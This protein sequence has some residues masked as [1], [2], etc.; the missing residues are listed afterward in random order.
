MT[1]KTK[2]IR[3][4]GKVVHCGLYFYLGD[5]T[6]TTWWH[7]Y[8]TKWDDYHFGYLKTTYVICYYNWELHGTEEMERPN[9]YMY[10]IMWFSKQKSITFFK[11]FLM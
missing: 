9:A 2:C 4:L 1:P 5:V 6:I 11:R 10:Y 3:H 7:L 8:I